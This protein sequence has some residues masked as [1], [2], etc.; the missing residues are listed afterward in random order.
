MRIGQCLTCSARGARPGSRR[1]GRPCARG[2]RPAWPS[3]SLAAQPG[4]RHRNCSR[5]LPRGA[6]EDH[7]PQQVRKTMETATGGGRQRERFRQVHRQVRG[8]NPGLQRALIALSNH[9]HSSCRPAKSVC[10]DAPG[11]RGDRR[12]ALPMPIHTT[13]PATTSN[14]STSPRVSPARGQSQVPMG[15]GRHDG[16]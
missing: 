13:G 10:V 2:R 15:G 7:D 3:G 16:P 11:A 14:E 9:A 1:A 8:L 6:K 4:Y 5:P 12:H